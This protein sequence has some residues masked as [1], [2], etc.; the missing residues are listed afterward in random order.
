MRFGVIS[1]YPTNDWHSR[2]LIAACARR[3]H[4]E[5]FAPTAFCL[6]VARTP[7]V[8]AAGRDAR[9]IDA[10]LLPRA[11]GRRGD[12]DFQLG[13]YR[14]L[15][16]L[17]RPLVNDVDALLAAEDKPQTSWRL[18]RAGIAT[19]PARVV[20]SLPEAEA[21][22][23]ELGPAVVKPPYGSLGLGVE[24]VAP[25]RDARRPLARV[26]RAHGLAYLQAL[27]GRG[28]EDLRLF[29][30]GGCVAAA[31]RRRAAAGQFLTNAHQGATLDAVAP[32]A[33]VERLAVRAA[34]ALGLAYAGVDIIET[35][36]G[37]TVLEVNGAP[38]WRGLLEATGH[39]M[40]DAIVAL[41]AARAGGRNHATT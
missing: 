25:G 22:L 3:G 23:A 36:A 19:P 17:G 27:V 8:L 38:R 1:A 37:P 20:Q 18:A 31:I 16:E 28:R 14:A 12:P 2:R 6:R 35:D 32:G 5:V 24:A 4:V 7:L 10:W 33:R 9:R 11:L 26:L 15:G 41:A 39:D 40:A 13:V 21:A 34:R 29:V 30:V